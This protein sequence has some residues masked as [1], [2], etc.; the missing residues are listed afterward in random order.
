[1][2]WRSWESATWAAAIR[3]PPSKSVQSRL[4][5]AQ[6]QIVVTV[7][8]LLLE[9]DQ[10]TIRD[11][12]GCELGPGDP[13]ALHRDLNGALNDGELAP[14]STAVCKQSA[15]EEGNGGSPAARRHGP[16]GYL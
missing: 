4:D 8:L 11:D 7:Q 16:A 5:I 14:L 2:A 3:R 9:V 1:M 6:V 12:F 10:G 15:S 13:A